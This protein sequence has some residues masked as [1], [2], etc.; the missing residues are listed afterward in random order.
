[1]ALNS[2]L[3]A[4]STSA[5]TTEAYPQPYFCCLKNAKITEETEE[6]VL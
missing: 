4:S 6:K 3:H 1:M 2:G 5:L